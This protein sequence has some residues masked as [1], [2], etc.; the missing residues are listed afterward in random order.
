VMPA[1]EIYSIKP[2]PDGLSRVTERR[3]SAGVHRSWLVPAEH[4]ENTVLDEWAALHDAVPGYP[5]NW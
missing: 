4:A 3:P 5:P 2:G 1:L